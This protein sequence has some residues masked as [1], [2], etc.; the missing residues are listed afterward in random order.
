MLTGVFGGTSDAILSKAK[1][2]IEEKATSSYFPKTELFEKFNEAKPAL[3]LKITEDLISRAS[4]NSAESYLILSLLYKNSVNLSPLL[5][6]NKP[7]QDHIFS[8][9]EMK[10]AQIPKEKINSIYNIRWVSAS[11][12]RI[13]S[14]ESYDD[15]S[16]RFGNSV[17]KSHFIPDG[18]W[19]VANFDAF[20]EARKIEFVKAIVD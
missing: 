4:Y 13:K 15:W 18:N 6:D 14:D 9:K 12:N 20:L 2:A 17:S 8:K 16:V 7:Q 5:D 3:T 11:D 19:S 1:K 10:V